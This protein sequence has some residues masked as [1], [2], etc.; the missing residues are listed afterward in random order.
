MPEDFMKSFRNDYSH[1]SSAEQLG[2][3]P[4]Y[5]VWEGHPTGLAT[6]PIRPGQPRAP[7]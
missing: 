4:P 6:P 2:V 3:K 5:Y 1:L 7:P